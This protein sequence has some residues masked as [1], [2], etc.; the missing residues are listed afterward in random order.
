M[1]QAVNKPLK[2][3][4]KVN[5]VVGKKSLNE[6][7]DNS[8]SQET[9]PV[10][11][12]NDDTSSTSDPKDYENKKKTQEESQVLNGNTG[13]KKAIDPKEDIKKIMG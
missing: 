1:E 9:N 11:K 5:D 6:K 4:N 8:G 12:R 13:D 3:T 10:P 7:T 2:N